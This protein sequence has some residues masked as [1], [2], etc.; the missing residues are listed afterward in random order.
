MNYDNDW[1][2]LLISRIKFVLMIL[3]EPFVYY[4]RQLAGRLGI[5]DL[6][7][8]YY[9]RRK[10]VPIKSSLVRVCVH[11]WG[12]YAL[13]RKK[14]FSKNSKNICGLKYQLQR[15]SIYRKKGLVDL[16]VTMS[17]MSKSN[18]LNEVKNYCD[19]FIP[20]S[21]IGMDFRGYSTFFNSIIN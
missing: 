7:S 19:H 17:D 10:R 18:D 1:L 8:L 4:P 12:G 11:E 16:T 15:F 20:V 6:K 21:N 2:N 5:I 9:G 14:L 13:E 3:T